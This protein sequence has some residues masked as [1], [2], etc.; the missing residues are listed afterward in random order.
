MTEEY[1][2]DTSKPLELPPYPNSLFEWTEDQVEYWRYKDDR[3]NVH[4]RASFK[5]WNVWLAW[6]DFHND[7]KLISII[8][9]KSPEFTDDFYLKQKIV[10]MT[11]R[12]GKILGQTN[13]TEEIFKLSKE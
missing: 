9:K 5:L 6:V 4:K 10:D 3:Q 13:I 8:S 1:T 2:E 11:D 12:L 7:E